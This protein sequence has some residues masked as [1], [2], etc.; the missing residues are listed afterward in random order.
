MISLL[1]YIIATAILAL[2]SGD[3]YFYEQRVEMRHFLPFM[4]R[5]VIYYDK[6]HVHIMKN[7]AIALNH[8]ATWPKF[9]ESP[10][11]QFKATIFDQIGFS[12]LFCNPE[13]REFLK[14]KAQ[15]VSHYGLMGQKLN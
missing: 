15:S 4:K 14:T 1:G 2:A 11:T 3:M 8:Y 7:G 12:S 5:R 13:I 6:M 9:W 10:Y